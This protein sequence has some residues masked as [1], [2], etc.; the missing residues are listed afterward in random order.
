MRTAAFLLL[1]N[2]TFSTANVLW[3]H[4]TI[5]ST[6]GCYQVS[7]RPIHKDNPLFIIGF[8]TYLIAID[9]LNSL[10]VLERV[11]L[12]HLNLEFS[13]KLISYIYLFTLYKSSY[14][15]CIFISHVR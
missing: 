12:L 11:I 15:F 1:K 13:T 5:V 7:T 10:Y 3:K 4:E 2:H 14:C 6:H 9:Y 8:I